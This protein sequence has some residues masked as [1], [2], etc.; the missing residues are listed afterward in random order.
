MGRSGI[1]IDKEELKR[2]LQELP[3]QQKVAD[4]FNVS[5]GTI[6][7]K[8]REYELTKAKG[9]TDRD[10]KIEFPSLS[11]DKAKEILLAVQDENSPTIGYDKVEIEIES[12]GNILMVPI[13]DLHIGARYNY[14]RELIALIDLIVENPQVYTGFNGDLA[15]NYN[16]SA[17][18]SGQ[19]EQSLPV[20]KQKAIVEALVRKLQ[21]KIL[22]FV[23]G[24]HDEWSYF[25]DGFDLA[26]YLA[27][28]DREGYYMGHH[29]RV[30]IYLN[31]ERYKLFVIHNTYN[32][33]Q[34][35]KGHGLKW[36]CREEVGYDI[37]I[38][39]HNHVANTEE[40]VMRGKNRYSMCGSAW[41]GQDRHGSKEGFPPTGKT[42]PG[43]ILSSKTKTII[44]D[45][46]YRNLV[47]YL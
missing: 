28:K 37:G 44:L 36:V 39:A 43:F 38:K 11:W 46:D 45:I 33:S 16:T 21:G 7:N 22:W 8:V 13:M 42:T 26:Q 2:K 3:T 41:K 34:L 15:D 4:H 19:I 18:K 9:K 29:G 40:F 35:N 17:Y 47:K 30:D 5:Q 31:G 27:H 23:N 1:V 24:C 25:N 32:N 10:E 14:S 6:S 12:A 20:M